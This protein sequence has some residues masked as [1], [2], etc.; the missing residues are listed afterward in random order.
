MLRKLLN[1]VKKEIKSNNFLKNIFNKLIKRT[2]LKRFLFFYIFKPNKF[3][4]K[5]NEFKL[6]IVFKK[7]I[8]DPEHS[9][10]TIEKKN[11]FKNVQ[12][13]FSKK[14]LDNAIAILRAY[15]CF[16]IW[17]PLIIKVSKISDQEICL[18]FNMSDKGEKKF[19]SMEQEN[20]KNLI[21]DL[22]AFSASSEI[23]K[24]KIIK[25]EFIDFKNIWLS[26][27]NKIFWRG[28]TTGRY[29]R[30]IKELNSTTRIIICKSFKNVKNIDFKITKIRQNLI[31]EI[32]VKK[33][34]IAED[35][36]AEE[37]SEDKFASYRY[38]PDIPGNSLGWGTIKK[39]L[40]GNLIFKTNNEKQ[41]FYYQ[42]LHPWVHYIP[43]KDD[44]SDLEEKFNWSQENID[45]TINIAYRGYITIFDYI[46]NIDKHF[47]NSLLKYRP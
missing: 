37:V 17:L 21:P 3:R 13:T 11:S 6:D 27:E 42:Y 5:Y 46:K 15:H 34:L 35:I 28:T 9:R 32:E 2:P 26:K 31:S 1:Y 43:V 44:F 4:R 30:S 36:F 14:V 16:D 22:Y 25:Q 7:E 10:L 38:Y 47:I 23:I 8:Q 40:S 33:Y 29:Y 41:L 24:K 45:E 18:D 20:R 19:L 39:Y 12:I